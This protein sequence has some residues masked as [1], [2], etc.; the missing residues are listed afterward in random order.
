MSANNFSRRQYTIRLNP[1]LIMNIRTFV[2]LIDLW[3]LVA[4][5]L[6]LSL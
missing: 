3:V 2:F 6:S 1:Q 5:R 4:V